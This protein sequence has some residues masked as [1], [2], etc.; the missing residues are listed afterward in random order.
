MMVPRASLLTF[1][2]ILQICLTPFLMRMR[3]KMLLASFGLF[4]LTMMTLFGDQW[5]ANCTNNDNT[6]NTNNSQ[7]ITRKSDCP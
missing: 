1:L 2:S 3:T 6:S 5:P 7:L 4:V